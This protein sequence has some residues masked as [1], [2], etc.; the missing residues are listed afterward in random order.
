LAKTDTYI[1]RYL[2]CRTLNLIKDA[3]GESFS[4]Y[5]ARK[6]FLTNIDSA[7]KNINIV[8]KENEI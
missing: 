3:I 2:P 5:N 1:D 7:F 8:I 4:D 6:I